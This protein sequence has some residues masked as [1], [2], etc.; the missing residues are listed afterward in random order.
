MTAKGRRLGVEGSSER[1]KGLMDMDNQVVIAGGEG[2]LRGLN[3]N[4]KNMIKKFKSKK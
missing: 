1:E 3:G 2:C 4:G